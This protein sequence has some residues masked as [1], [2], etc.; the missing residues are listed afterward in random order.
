[1]ALF[2]YVCNVCGFK[3]IE[4]TPFG[5]LAPEWVC[6]DCGAD[7]THFV[8]G[9]MPRF[10]ATI[11]GDYESFNAA[12]TAA[13][14]ANVPL[15]IHDALVVPLNTVEANVVNVF[16]DEI[17]SLKIR[18]DDSVVVGGEHAYWDVVQNEVTITAS[19]NTICGVFLEP[20]A[21]LDTDAYIRLERDSVDVAAI[22]AAIAAV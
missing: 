10:I 8:K 9:E 3:Y 13:T 17:D 7:K 16:A 18:K 4:G 11:T 14:C 5:E 21:A 1:M 12:H 20:A 15:L 2:L 22:Y 19:G 6:P